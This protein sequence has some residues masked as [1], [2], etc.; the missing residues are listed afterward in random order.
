M[1][2]GR[3]AT[4]YLGGKDLRSNMTVESNGGCINPSFATSSSTD[5][6]VLNC[7]VKV[8]GDL[9]LTSKAED[10]TVVYTTTLNV[11]LYTG[12]GTVLL[13]RKSGRCDV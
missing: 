6:L 7:G 3:T 12:T 10:G 9:P 1:Q 11:L 13:Y 8:V 2:Y 4:I 5:T